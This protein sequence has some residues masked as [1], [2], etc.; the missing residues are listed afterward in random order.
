MR[1]KVHFGKRMIKFSFF[2][3]FVITS[4]EFVNFEPKSY[5][6][7]HFEIYFVSINAHPP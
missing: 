4:R 5:A 6:I 3:I 7:S 2:K 1:S